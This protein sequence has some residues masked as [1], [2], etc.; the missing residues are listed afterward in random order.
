M[1]IFVLSIANQEEFNRR[2]NHLSVVFVW[3]WLIGLQFEK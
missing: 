1:G 2:E 3:Q